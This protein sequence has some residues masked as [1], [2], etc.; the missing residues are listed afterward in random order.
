GAVRTA[1]GHPRGAA[2][3]SARHHGC[4]GRARR[5]RRCGHDVLSRS[6]V[7]AQRGSDAFASA[8]HLAPALRRRAY[9]G[10]RIA[11]GLQL[12]A[13]SLA[14]G[15]TGH[16]RAVAGRRGQPR[17]HAKRH[18]S[19]GGGAAERPGRIAAR[20]AAQRD[21]HRA[22]AVLALR[23]RV[24]GGALMTETVVIGAGPAG[25]AVAACLRRAGRE[26]VIVDRAAEVGSAWPRPY[27]RP[28]L[29]TAKRRSALPYRKF[30]R[31]WPTY[32]SREQFVEYLEEYAR[33]FELAPR[34][35]ETVTRA[36]PKEDGWRVET[37][38]GVLQSRFLV[39][40]TGHNAV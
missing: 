25:L 32:I 24:L 35:G 18:A 6:A 10:P 2:A 28:H 29:H 19:P 36:A 17:A 20:P 26:V 13:R 22:R 38:A 12:S 1:G 34:L 31:D 23:H 9:H 40:A 39:V 11:R 5:S 37:S 4:P 16:A 14:H 27:E 33:A 15:T 8:A 7:R 3:G 21:G 30:P